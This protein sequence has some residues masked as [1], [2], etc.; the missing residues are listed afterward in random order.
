MHAPSPVVARR[1]ASTPAQG[2][3]ITIDALEPRRL[4]AAAVVNN[5]SFES[6]A[7]TTEPAVAKLTGWT[8]PSG[9][10]AGTFNPS[11][12][13]FSGAND[14]AAGQGVLAAP[15]SG[16]QHLFINGVGAVRQTLSAALQPNLRYR[17]TVAVGNRI[18]QTMESFR[19][20]LFAGDTRI[21]VVEGDGEADVASGRFKD[22]VATSGVY[23]LSSALV[24]QPIRVELAGFD[25]KAGKAIQVDFDNVRVETLPPTTDTYSINV[26]NGSFE[27]LKAKT[28]RSVVTVSTWGKVGTTVANAFNPRN[29]SFTNADDTGPTRGVLAA[30]AA[31]KQ[32]LFINGAGTVRQTLDTTFLAGRTYKLTVAV[33]NRGDLVMENYRIS[34]F[35]GT[36]RIATVTGDGEAVPSFTFKDVSASAA[37]VAAG[38]PLVGQAL[39]IELTN[40][41][42]KSGGGSHQVDF[43]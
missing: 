43:D 12:S 19:A 5:P 34:L 17:L 41:G 15:A 13:I 31:G 42:T 39:R 10:V 6:K 35:A 11:G 4:F 40:L 2:R 24:G 25:T 9:V 30:P 23:A 16:K 18:D 26:G 1:A 38:S 14:S 32:H 22:F 8:I 20:S 3:A 29:E 21:A 36:T 33:G 7:T 37:A 27:A 28:D